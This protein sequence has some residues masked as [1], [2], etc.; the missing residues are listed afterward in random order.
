MKSVL[1]NGAGMFI[2]HDLK[3]D[4]KNLK[5]LILL[6]ARQKPNAVEKTGFSEER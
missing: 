5:P 3:L 1:T 2:S 4:Q 6:M